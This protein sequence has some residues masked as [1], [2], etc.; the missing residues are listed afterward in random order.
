MYS[1]ASSMLRET[2]FGKLLSVKQNCSERYEIN[3]AGRVAKDGFCGIMGA[4]SN[5]I[6]MQGGPG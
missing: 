3:D 6:R 4:H 5:R 1:T 2:G